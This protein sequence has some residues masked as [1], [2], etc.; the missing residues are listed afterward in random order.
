MFKSNKVTKILKDCGVIKISTGFCPAK[1]LHFSVLLR[2]FYSVIMINQNVCLKWAVKHLGL[3]PRHFA[4]GPSGRKC[5]TKR[6]F[7]PSQ[8]RKSCCANGRKVIERSNTLIRDFLPNLRNLIRYPIYEAVFS[9]AK[10]WQFLSRHFSPF[11][12]YIACW[13]RLTFTLS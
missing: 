9:F 13:Y 3:L 11:F 2:F 7:L 6:L 4:R 1:I 12:F 8:L 5:T 10:L